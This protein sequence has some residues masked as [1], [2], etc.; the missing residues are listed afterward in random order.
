MLMT[1]NP[2]MLPVADIKDHHFR[3]LKSVLLE[4]H[5]S[6]ITFVNEHLH[7]FKKHL[8]D[9]ETFEK[10][11]MDDAV[12]TAV[13]REPRESLHSYHK[14]V[15]DFEFRADEVMIDKFEDL[16]KILHE[17]KKKL[18][19]MDSTEL[20]KD[21]AAFLQKYCEQCGIAFDSQMLSWK[22]AEKGSIF[23]NNKW[24][25]ALANSTGFEPYNPEK[26]KDAL[27]PLDPRY[28]DVISTNLKIYH[29]LLSDS[30]R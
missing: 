2:D 23:Y 6:D 11:V 26:A 3:H 16:V 25:G 1:Y 4:D 12:H 17:K 15:P 28:E 10:M 29:T 21:P 18:V 13:I 7:V 9:S 5:G 20:L 8:M 24:F 30:I 14:V 22:R 19:V 27:A